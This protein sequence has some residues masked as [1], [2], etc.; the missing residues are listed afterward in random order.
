LQNT[1]FVI[2]VNTSCS[3]KLIYKLQ[4]SRIGIYLNYIGSRSHQSH[5]TVTWHDYRIPS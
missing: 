3:E 4:K 2:I 5:A 1:A